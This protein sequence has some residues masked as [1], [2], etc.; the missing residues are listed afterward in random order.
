[1]LSKFMVRCRVDLTIG[2]PGLVHIYFPSRSRVT[3]MP[4]PPLRSV[5]AAG[6]T[7]VQ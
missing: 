3:W 7:P 2:K 5:I 1:M 4:F 6:L